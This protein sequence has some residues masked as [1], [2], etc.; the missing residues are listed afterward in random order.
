M[1]NC[2]FILGMHRSGTSALGGT[3]NLMGFDFGSDLM[4]ANEDNPKGYFENNL[5]YE[6]NRK[7]LR[8]KNSSWDDYGFDIRKIK[9]VQ[10]KQYVFEAK[11]NYSK[12]ISNIR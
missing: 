7:I 2:T 6:L 4:Q 1:K 5:V 9:E 8:E 10:F 3:L 11:K 12:S